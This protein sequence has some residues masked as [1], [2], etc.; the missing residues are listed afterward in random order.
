M[1]MASLRMQGALQDCGHVWGTVE[2][3]AVTLLGCSGPHV[4]SAISPPPQ[5]LCGLGFSSRVLVLFCSV[6]IVL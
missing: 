6:W 4:V 2:V 5:S 1:R 3:M